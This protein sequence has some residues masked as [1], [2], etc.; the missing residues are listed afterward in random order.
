ML[1]PLTRAAT[2]ADR[3]SLD[4][5]VTLISS[6]NVRR[7]LDISA[8]TEWRWRRD[9]LIPEPVKIRGRCYYK[10]PEIEA[11]VTRLVA[12]DEQGETGRAAA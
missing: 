4:P 1:T 10:L 12:L 9:G 8:M 3:N 2:A 11:A 5:T 6:A 7:Q